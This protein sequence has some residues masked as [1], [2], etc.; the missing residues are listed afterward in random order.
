MERKPLWGS[1]DAFPKKWLYPM[2][3]KRKICFLK[4]RKESGGGEECFKWGVFV[5]AWGRMVCGAS[6]EIQV[7]LAK[8]KWEVEWQA[9]QSVYWGQGHRPDRQGPGG[10]FS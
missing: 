9:C 3:W 4:V 2:R 8:S 5:K 10:Q 1:K 7:R 6:Q